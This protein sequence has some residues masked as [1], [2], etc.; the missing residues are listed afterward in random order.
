ML[1]RYKYAVVN[2]GRAGRATVGDGAAKLRPHPSPGQ[3]AWRTRCPSPIGTGPP[4]HGAME[5]SFLFET[6]RSPT[7]RRIGDQATMHY[8][9][10]G[11]RRPPVSA[12]PYEKRKKNRAAA[13]WKTGV[14][15]RV[16]RGELCWSM[17][18]DSSASFRPAC[19]PSKLDQT[20]CQLLRLDTLNRRYLIR[21]LGPYFRHR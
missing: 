18:Y 3:R 19:R 11:A 12:P 8:K 21:N 4:P 15:W 13:S 14:A 6:E 1:H 2:I 9:S 20:V 10:G 7:K 5:T 17:S 16:Y